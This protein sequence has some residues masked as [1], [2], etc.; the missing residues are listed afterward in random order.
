MSF[1]PTERIV[2]YV[3]DYEKARFGKITTY[4][5]AC[6]R[7]FLSQWTVGQDALENV[8]CVECLK[9]LAGGKTKSE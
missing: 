5:T 3:P 8:T 9:F 2:H 7:W 6:G 4:E 1:E